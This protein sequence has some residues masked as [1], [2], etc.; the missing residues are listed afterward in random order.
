[1]KLIALSPKGY[2]YSRRNRMD[3]LITVAAVL[4]AVLHL[5]FRST[6]LSGST[7]DEKNQIKNN[8]EIIDSIG[9]GVIILRFCTITGK[10]VSLPIVV[11]NLVQH[12]AHFC[13][14]TI[15]LYTL[16]RFGFDVWLS[17]PP[18]LKYRPV[19]NNMHDKNSSNYF[20][21][22]AYLVME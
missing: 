8:R 15:N 11:F 3:L 13:A 9:Y 17:L 7:E 22:V 4:W 12:S 6:P 5:S 1:M 2:W 14:V 20:T 19:I 10:H 18:S 21:D 16:K